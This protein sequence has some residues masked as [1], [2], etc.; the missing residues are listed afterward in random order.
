MEFQSSSNENTARKKRPSGAGALEGNHHLSTLLTKNQYITIEVVVNAL[1]KQNERALLPTP[2]RSIAI[3]A[4]R[5]TWDL[6]RE[7]KPPFNCANLTR[8][9][10]CA[11]R[12]ES[13][14]VAEPRSGGAGA[15]S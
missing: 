1:R 2:L 12:S 11:S 5:K 15:A 4:R 9:F 14:M 13:Q 3:A 6:P 10:S 7:M 8:S